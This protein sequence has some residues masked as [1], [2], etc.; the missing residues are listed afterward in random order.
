MHHAIITCQGEVGAN[1]RTLTGMGAP[2]ARTR[3]RALA[4]LSPFTV[5][6]FRGVPGKKFTTRDTVTGLWFTPTHMGMHAES[7]QLLRR[8]R[9][10][11]GESLEGN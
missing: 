2:T 6:E 11:H 5:A 4:L 3:T 8:V 10:T 7:V 1:G 9:R